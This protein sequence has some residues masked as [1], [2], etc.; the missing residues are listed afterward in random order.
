MGYYYSYLYLKKLR[1][2][3]IKKIPKVTQLQMESLK[4]NP[5]SLNLGCVLS[6]TTG[7]SRVWLKNEGRL[8]L[9][10]SWDP[11]RCPSE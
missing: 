1:H 10:C 11:T 3:E 6:R 8:I 5:D 7:I 4:M 9:D 2:R